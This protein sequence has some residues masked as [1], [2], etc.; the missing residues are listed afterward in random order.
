MK[1]LVTGGA[2]FIGSWIVDFLINENIDVVVLDNLSTGSLKNFEHLEDK[3]AKINFYKKDI[4]ALE[5]WEIFEREKPDY[6]FH[7]AAEISV[8][9]SIENPRKCEDV[10]VL[11][12][13]NVLRNCVEYGIK[14]FI[15]SSTGGA[16]Y[17]DGVRIPT[18]ETEEE[19]PASPYGISKLALEKYLDFFK[20]EHGLNYVSLRYSNV[21]GPRQNSKG[22]AGVVAIFINNLLSGK[23][24]RINGSG[25][26]TRDY[27]Y[28]Q[29]VARANLLALNGSLSGVF[30]VGT[31]IETDV[32]ELYRKITKI[33]D[34]NVQAER[35][36]SIR[37]EQMRSCL[38][39]GKLIN[40]GWSIKSNLESG[41][42]ETIYSFRGKIR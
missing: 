20:K 24:P 7:T 36:L 31:G 42:Q 13:L 23:T 35:G 26:Q 40:A 12:S 25:E 30:N 6:V 5:L 19:K 29:D 15:F 34:L 18:P 41:L 2:G 9:D 11:G 10:N 14:K 3:I 8:R 4:R 39:A 38:D 21:Y 16:I 17:G 37:G 28:V 1:A 32:N 22:E 27:V 33:M